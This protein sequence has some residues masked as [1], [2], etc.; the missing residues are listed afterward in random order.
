[1]TNESESKVIL[2]SLVANESETVMDELSEAGTEE[3]GQ[4]EFDIERN[5]LDNEELSNKDEHPKTKMSILN[6][7]DEAGKIGKNNGCRG[8]F[9]VAKLLQI[10]SLNL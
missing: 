2:Q 6:L 3:T 9:C 7:D 4:H 10:N 8:G 5:E 1:M